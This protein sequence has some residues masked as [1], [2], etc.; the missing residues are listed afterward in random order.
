[1]PIN[2]MHKIFVLNLFMLKMVFKWFL[3]L[4]ANAFVNIITNG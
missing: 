2:H 1:M 3:F 4:K